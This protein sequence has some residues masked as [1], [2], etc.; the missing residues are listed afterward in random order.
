VVDGGGSSSSTLPN[1]FAATGQLQ[2]QAVGY[3]TNQALTGMKMENISVHNVNSGE[4]EYTSIRLKRTS[5]SC[6]LVRGSDP[7]GTPLIATIYRWGP[8]RPP[9]MRIL[10]PQTSASVDAAINSDHIECEPVEVRS[11][12]LISRAQKLDTS[13]GT[14]EWRYGSRTERKEAYDAASL[15]I[16]E[17]TDSVS[18]VCGKKGKRGVR[19]AQLVR[20]DEFRTPGTNKHMGGNGGR[21]MM[22]LSMW[23]DNKKASAKDVEAFVVASCI[24]MLK[25]EAD[26]F[27]D[28]QVSTVV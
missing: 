24:C 13:F 9:R 10:P 4:S 23:T 19:V 15:L 3:D 6:A 18:S 21:L 26:R 14:F 17:R 8:G 22:D 28:N 20:N 2:I 27:R 5:N 25:R 7:N 1:A 11:R 16:M 12:S